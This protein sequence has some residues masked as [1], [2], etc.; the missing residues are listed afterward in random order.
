MGGLDHALP[1][2]ANIVLLD[3][4]AGASRREGIAESLYYNWS[5]EFPVPRDQMLWVPY[6]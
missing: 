6:P 4:C 1:R 5:K 2:G 3:A